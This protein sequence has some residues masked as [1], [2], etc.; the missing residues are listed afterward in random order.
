MRTLTSRK[1]K[2]VET[3]YTDA[4]ALRV[5][6][7]CETLEGFGCD[8]VR[9]AE[10]YGLTADQNVWVHVLASEIAGAT[11]SEA[12]VEGFAPIVMYLEAAR[13]AGIKWPKI[14]LVTADLRPVVLS[15]AGNRAKRPGTA[16]I[17]DGGPYEQNT[18]Y[19]RISVGGILEPGRK[20]DEGVVEVLKAFADDPAGTARAQGSLTS[21]CCFCGR[22]LET[23][24]SVGAG[25]GPVCAGRWGLP[26]GEE[27]V[28]EYAGKKEEAIEAAL[29][30]VGQQASE[31]QLAR[32][33]TAEE[34][35]AVDEAERAYDKHLERWDNDL[36][37]RM[38]SGEQSQKKG[39]PED[40]IDDDE[41]T[42]FML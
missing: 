33:R 23:M 8:L 38:S 27:T 24:E 1:G 36:T 18:W 20:L 11:E 22:T 30:K 35:E 26:W 37:Y 42:S 40:G 12:P 9:K 28:A 34:Q 2:T 16:N 15:L 5:L 13:A 19:G 7:E 6:E 4:E 3:N 17:T 32:V 39:L 25:Y 21:N 31:Y 14:R 29:E 41:L 10:K